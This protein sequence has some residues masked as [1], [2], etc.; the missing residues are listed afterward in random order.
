MNR[1]RSAVAFMS[2][3]WSAALIAQGSGKPFAKS[4]DRDAIRVIASA[5]LES[6]GE[7]IFDDGP[8]KTQSRLRVE[9]PDSLDPMW[10]TVK[11]RLVRIMDAQPTVS[12]DRT[13]EY[14]IF[15][16][17]E[18]NGDELTAI[19][20]VGQQWPCGNGSAISAY[21]TTYRSI[22]LN[23][24]WQRATVQVVI[25]VDPPPCPRDEVAPAI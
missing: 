9:V 2:I 24:V 10:K 7:R 22:R 13:F 16:S 11:A 8:H 14:I 3:T 17:P 21:E 25:A 23:G 20:E 15:R 19:V 5:V 4:S 18:F 1:L 6:L 12:G